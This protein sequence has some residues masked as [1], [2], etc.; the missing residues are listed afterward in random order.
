MRPEG[1]DGAWL[2]AVRE[3]VDARAAAY[4]V[5]VERVADERARERE[6]AR[7]AR[8]AK[9]AARKAER[10]AGKRAARGEPGPDAVAQTSALDEETARWLVVLTGFDGYGARERM[11]RA[12]LADDFEAVRC[13]AVDRG[14]CP[15]LVVLVG[16]LLAAREESVPA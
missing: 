6:A 9:L 7:A 13:A 4:R 2:A 1:T 8:E 5:T 12:L 16:V 15:G 3:A 10:D 11:V 14:L